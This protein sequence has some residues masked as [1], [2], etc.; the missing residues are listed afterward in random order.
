M[1]LTWYA[2]PRC[3]GKPLHEQLVQANT[4]SANATR[5]VVASLAVFDTEDR[6]A[7]ALV[8]G[9]VALDVDYVRTVNDSADDRIGDGVLAELCMLLGEQARLV[10][11][12]RWLLREVLHRQLFVGGVT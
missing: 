11:R 8:H 5:D 9:P 6:L 3:A 1:R 7:D 12:R 4:P 2:T 10:P